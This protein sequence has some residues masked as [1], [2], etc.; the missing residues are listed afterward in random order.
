MNSCA[1]KSRDSICNSVIDARN[2]FRLLKIHNSYVIQ[3]AI[4]K[5]NQ[6]I[7]VIRHAVQ[8]LMPIVGGSQA[9]AQV[10]CHF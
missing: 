5:K 4:N 2:F 8:K 10:L 6:Y 3:G 9:P 1:D 7:G